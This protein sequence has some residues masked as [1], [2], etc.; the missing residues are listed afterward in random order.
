[1]LISILPQTNAILKDLPEVC[2]IP[3]DVCADTTRDLVVAEQSHEEE[4]RAAL[5]VFNLVNP[6]TIAWSEVVASIAKS[7]GVPM[8][9][10]VS[11]PEYVEILS[12]AK[13]SSVERLLPYFIA[14]MAGE[15]L[16]TSYPTWDVLQSVELS[17]SL[18][19]CPP[20]EGEFLALMANKVLESAASIAAEAAAQVPVPPPVSLPSNAILAFGPWSNQ[21]PIQ[22][23]DPAF[24]ALLEE[25]QD[26]AKSAL[27]RR[28]VLILFLPA[29]LLMLW[30]IPAGFR[31]PLPQPM[32]FSPQ[33]RPFG[34]NSAPWH[35]TSRVLIPSLN[36]VLTLSPLWVTVTASSPLP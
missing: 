35:T 19:D 32:L 7:I 34:I 36:V 22:S 23:S 8:P 11:L 33:R 10:I 20:I 9:R 16:P 13:N 15:G 29:N 25:L 27:E 30:A 1:M 12:H 17:E 4:D 31:S 5:K 28:Y 24:E 6:K 18:R 14:C 26:L 21:I 2:W 3:V